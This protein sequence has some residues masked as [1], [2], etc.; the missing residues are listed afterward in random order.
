MNE[1]KLQSDFSLEGDQPKAVDELCESLNGGNS[2]QTLLGVTGSGKTFTMANVIQR[3][4]RPTL[5]IAHNKTLAAQ[6]CGEF[7]EF[8]PENAVEYFVSYYDYYQ[9][10][11]YIPQTDTYIEKDASINDEIDK[12]RHSATSALFERRDVIIVASVS[13]IYGLGSPEEYREQVLSLRCGMEKDRDEILKGLVDIQYSR[14]D[15]N[16]TRGTFRV[17]GDVI[18]VFPASYTETAVRIELFGDEIERIT[19]IDT[20]TGEILGERNHVA[21]FPASHFVTRR[22]KLEKAIESIQEELHEQLEYLKRQGKAVEAKRLEQRTN[23]DLEM[24]QEMGFCQG[25]ENY[26]RHLIGRPAGS[27]P[28]CLI[29]YFPDD[30]LMVVDESHMT[31][32][33][34]R[35]MYAGDM[36]RKQNLV[37]H[38]FRLPSALDNRPLKFQEFEKMINQNIYVSATPGPYEK[39]HSERIVEQIIRPTGLVDPET[40]VRPVKGQIDDLYSEINKRTDRNERVL[41]TT[42]TKKMAEDLTDYLREMGIRVRYMHSEIDTLERMEIIRDL[43]LGKFD[44]LVGIN[45][46]REGLDLPE[47]SLV[48]ILDADKEGYLRDERS[49]IQTMGRAARNVNGRVIM[50]GDAITDSMRRAIDETNRRRE[51]QIE[52]N[53]RHNITPQT[54]QKK[55][56]DVIEAT[57]S[58]E[59][60]TEAA[61]PE[62]IQEMSAKE[63]KELIAKLQEEMKQAAKELEFEKAAELRDLIMELKTAQ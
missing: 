15:V 28:Y 12:L 63:R 37:D 35:G 55:V 60:E 40:E 39:E 32:P 57:R 1:F 54:V 51:K 17:R 14:N 13:C 24:L 36:S 27:R 43:R 30:Y 21:I 45:L 49:L 10:E 31:I 6:L 47:V 33:Q 19:E 38:G 8:F 22:S 23:Y 58:A 16:F 41:V 11:A 59:D 61:T 25:I 26:S 44:V 4:Q 34:I 7:K 18:E 48:A 42:L 52:F 29:D 20:L 5:V 62:N 2:H 53:A 50:Y 3:L 9:P 56:H 46:L